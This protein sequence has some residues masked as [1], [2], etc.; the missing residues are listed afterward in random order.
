MNRERRPLDVSVPAPSVRDGRAL[1]RDASFA[2]THRLFDAVRDAGRISS[3]WNPELCGYVAD[4][5][6]CFLMILAAFCCKARYHVLL[7]LR[8]DVWVA[9]IRW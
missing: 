6:T 3:P 2:T 1:P 5:K 9:G 8:S 4:V 7:R